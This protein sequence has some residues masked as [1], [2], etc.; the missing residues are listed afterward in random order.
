MAAS[1][2]GFNNIYQEV[3]QTAQEAFAQEYT[4]LTVGGGSGGTGRI[5]NASGAVGGGSIVQQTVDPR[6]YVAWD[7]VTPPR[8]NPVVK[9]TKKKVK[10]I[11][12]VVDATD[13]KVKRLKEKIKRHDTQLQME[14]KELKTRA[15]RINTIKVLKKNLESKSEI[16]SKKTKPELKAHY[17]SI[18]DRLIKDA[19]IQNFDTDMYQ[20]VIITTKPILVKALK[21]LLPK[22]AGVY[23]IRIDFNIENWKDAIKILNTTRHYNGYDSPT[24]SNGRPCWG[25]IARDIENEFNTQDLYELVIDL[26]DYIRSPDTSAGYLSN[27]GDKS[28]G[29]DIFFKGFKDRE[30]G[31]SFEKYEDNRETT[32]GGL[33][34]LVMGGGGG[35]ITPS[36]SVSPGISTSPSVTAGQMNDMYSYTL[37][38]STLQNTA[39]QMAERQAQI[40]EPLDP[41]PRPPEHSRTATPRDLVTDRLSHLLYILGIRETFIGGI[42]SQILEDLAPNEM[43]R[44]LELEITGEFTASLSVMVERG[45]EAMP[46]DPLADTITL[47]E[48]SRR[49]FLLTIDAHFLRPQLLR[50][51][52]ANRRNRVRY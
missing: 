33:E 45:L 36:I 50:D 6:Q 9:K 26:I 48:F 29:W 25:N 43:I 42:N 47:P 13:E 52:R 24:I 10:V 16:L 11:D 44:D 51:L 32:L 39:T 22:D 19:L 15:Q 27:N 2:G 46:I 12:A 20:R 41:V 8:I 38:E 23:Q 35:G 1:V 34:T 3:P 14:E 28:G 37:R 49:R 7:P 18:I 40:F 31:Y 4:S 21:W 17:Q 30:K 5:S